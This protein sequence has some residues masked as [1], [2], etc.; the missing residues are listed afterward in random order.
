MVSAA[1]RRAPFVRFLMLGNKPGLLG[2]RRSPLC[3]EVLTAVA[4]GCPNRGGDGQPGSRDSC[5]GTAGR[6]MWMAWLSFGCPYC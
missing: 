2:G 4:G 1:S 3:L 5:I 6:T